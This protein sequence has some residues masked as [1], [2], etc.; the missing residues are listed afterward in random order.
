MSRLTQPLQDNIHSDLA[1]EV[2]EVIIGIKIHHDEQIAR[3]SMEEQN[4]IIDARKRIPE[5][6]WEQMV[7]LLTRVRNEITECKIPF[8]K[9]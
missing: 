7:E 5:P 6:T 1:S 9:Y 4:K 3:E 2:N 8:K